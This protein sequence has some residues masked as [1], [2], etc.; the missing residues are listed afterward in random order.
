MQRSVGEHIQELERVVRQ[1]T[2]ELMHESDLH[3]RNELEGKI[4]A[5]EIA[6]RHYHAA[7]QVEQSL[8][9]DQR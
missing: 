9:G 8:T 2:A 6:L 4:R 7:L 3:A 1:L 5:A